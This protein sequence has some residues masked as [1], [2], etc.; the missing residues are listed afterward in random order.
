LNQPRWAPR[1]YPGSFLLIPPL[2]SP[3]ATQT[4]SCGSSEFFYS[5]LAHTSRW[6]IAA[7]LGSFFNSLLTYTFRSTISVFP[8]HFLLLRT[9]DELLWLI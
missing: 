2:L 1:A 5:L 6:A 3:H 9:S 8:G 4:S 7:C